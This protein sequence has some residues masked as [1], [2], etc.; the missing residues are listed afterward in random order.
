MKVLRT[1]GAGFLIVN[2]I[3][4]GLL[5]IA[6]TGC[7]EPTV[8]NAETGEIVQEGNALKGRKYVVPSLPNSVHVGVVEYTKGNMTYLIM[9]GVKG[10]CVVNYTLDS[11]EM[12]YHR[13]E[14]GSDTVYHPSTPPWTA[15]TISNPSHTVGVWR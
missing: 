14:V 2:A 12:T 9:E 10:M 8:A 3:C 5:I 15:P 1:I 11:I 4:G 13:I 7:A 6:P